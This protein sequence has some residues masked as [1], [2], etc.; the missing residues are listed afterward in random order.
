MLELS[1]YWDDFQSRVNSTI[2]CIA[3]DRLPGLERLT[4]HLTEGCNLG[5]EY[6]NM[7][8]SKNQMGETLAKKIVFEYREMGGKI[9]HFTGGEP[10]IVPYFESV[11]KYAKFLGLQVSSNTNAVQR[12]DV[13][14]IDKLKA[15]FDTAAPDEFNRT[16]GAPVFD[17]VVENM[18][19]YSE[20]M[21]GKMLSIT[22]VL[23]RKTYPHML[24]LARFVQEN[25]KVYNLY[26]SNY[27]GSNPEFAF[28]EAEI[29][30]MF[31][32]YIPKVLAYFKETGN[33]YSW[34]QLSLYKPTD[35]INSDCRFEENK[36]IP[37]YIQLSEM[38][39]DTDGRCYNCSHLF[40]DGVKPDK[41]V[42]VF[43]KHLWQCF[44]EIKEDLCGN[45][46]CLSEK[47]LNGCNTNLIGFNRAVAEGR[48][49]Y[50]SQTA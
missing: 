19:Y 31:A 30:D 23:N 25:F 13:S 3:Q 17:K 37:C 49:I 42:S 16:V 32:N 43:E 46:T 5:C 41:V 24:E 4:V 28:T 10:T 39:I 34:K 7:R 14:S 11:C 47:C 8:F 1:N 27:K 26:F 20:Q 50:D 44:S 48:H 18:K 40:R 21:A 33:R 38:T 15:S 45:Y 2:D 22:A 12:V 36:V 29:E 35:F 9:I 6:C